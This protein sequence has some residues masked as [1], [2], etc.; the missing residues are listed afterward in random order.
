MADVDVWN[1]R[2]E[3]IQSLQMN[4]ADADRNFTFRS[5]IVV[6]TGAFVKLADPTMRDIDIALT[7]KWAVG[8]DTRGQITDYGPA[9]RRSLSREHDDRRAHADDEG[10]DAARAIRASRRTARQ[11]LYWKD[12]KFQAWDLDAGDDADA[13]RRRRP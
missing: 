6:S 8:R 3:R 7:G 1:A 13:R 2:D 11:Y 12:S 9:D 4:R 5:A 10:G